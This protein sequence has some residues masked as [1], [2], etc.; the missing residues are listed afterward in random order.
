MEDMI[1]V[2]IIQMTQEFKFKKKNVFTFLVFN[3]ML[4]NKGLI[5]VT[6][7]NRI[8]RMYNNLIGIKQIEN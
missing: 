2:N 6:K 3:K 4:K 7:E 8:M 1:R 5:T